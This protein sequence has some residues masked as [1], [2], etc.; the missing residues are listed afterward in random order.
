MDKKEKRYCIVTAADLTVL[1]KKVNELMDEGWLPQGGVSWVYAGCSQAMMKPRSL[2]EEFAELF[3][4]GAGFY[5]LRNTETEVPAFMVE[6]LTN[7][8]R[9]I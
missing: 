1:E 6:D 5:E 3:G 8:D 2:E 4:E 7:A 9:E